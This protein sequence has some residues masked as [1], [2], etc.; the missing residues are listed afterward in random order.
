[1][2]ELPE[3]E[4]TVNGI[5]PYLQDHIIAKLLIRERRLRWPVEPSLEE[6]VEGERILRL[7]RRGKYIAI[8]LARG[9][10]IINLGMS[11]SMRVLLEPAPPQK[12]DHFDIVN[13]HGQVIRYR[14]PRKFGCLLYSEGEIYNHPRLVGL[15]VEPLTDEFDG[16]L[17]YLKSRTRNVAVKTFIM[18]AAIV[19]GV[20]NIYASE[21]LFLSGIHPLR[22]CSRISRPRYNML[23]GSIRDVLEKAIAKG[24]TTLQDFVG[25]DGSPG[26]FEQKL[27]V[28]GRQGKPCYRCSMVIKKRV[29][30]QRSTY[31]CSACQR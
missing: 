10:M 6:K 19:V 16:S 17:L 27:R 5:R 11:G 7:Y 1:M 31:Y 23:A 25:V 20:G 29:I 30:G 9:G 13:Q 26:Y 22:K 24:G 12:H 15:G 14:D 2:P 18:D 3:V 28:Y 4:T 21:A 8:E